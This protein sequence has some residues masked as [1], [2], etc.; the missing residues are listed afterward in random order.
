M[1]YFAYGAN[2]HHGQMARRCPGA[3]YR[4]CAALPG[5][6][7]IFRGC[8][9]L[10]PAPGQVVQGAIWDIDETHLLALD[11]YE[12]YP[13]FYGRERLTVEYEGCPVSAIVYLMQP[14]RSVV[15]PTASYLQALAEGYAAC[16]LPKE[17]LTA[18]ATRTYAEYDGERVYRSRQWGETPRPVSLGG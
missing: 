12:G 11:R 10:R 9:D 14:G 16:Q 15:P 4:G 2:T 7:L 6:E 18:A 1:R 17:Q 5:Y 3:R 8:A 13:T